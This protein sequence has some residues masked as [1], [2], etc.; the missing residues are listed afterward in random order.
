ML[1][2]HNHSRDEN[3]EE[4]NM[5]DGDGG[6]VVPYFIPADSVFAGLPWEAGIGGSGLVAWKG[7]RG[8]P[9]GRGK[10]RP[11]LEE[12]RQIRARYQEG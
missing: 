10:A 9:L 12:R 6:M 11:G 1:M 2:K 5:K 8:T 4:H 7:G 3:Y